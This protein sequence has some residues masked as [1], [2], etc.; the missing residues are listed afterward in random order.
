MHIYLI[1]L[2]EV[3]IGITEYNVAN[4][5]GYIDNLILF[6]HNVSSE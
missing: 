6:Q 4:T 2:Q 1:L 5:K 3:Y